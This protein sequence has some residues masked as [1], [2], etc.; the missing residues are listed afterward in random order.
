[1]PNK[2]AKVTITQEEQ[3]QVRETINSPGFKVIARELR[4][5]GRNAFVKKN[6]ADPYADPG[7][8]YEYAALHK[9]I[10]ILLPLLVESLANYQADA[11]DKQVEPKKRFSTLDLFSK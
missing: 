2:P 11:P 3:Q 6:V 9:S 1:M 8:F 7:K 4:K 10:N 5:Y